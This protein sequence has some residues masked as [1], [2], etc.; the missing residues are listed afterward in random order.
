MELSATEK[1]IAHQMCK[2]SANELLPNVILKMQGKKLEV[3]NTSW[4]ILV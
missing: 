4:F 2:P 1:A 3:K